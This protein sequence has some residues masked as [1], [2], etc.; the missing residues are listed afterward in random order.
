[1]HL[2]HSAIC[3]II[4]LLIYKDG[5]GINLSAGVDMPLNKE[6]KLNIIYIKK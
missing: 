5:F 1:M 3:L 4:I 6:T 2:S